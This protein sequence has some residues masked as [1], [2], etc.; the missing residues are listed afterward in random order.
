VKSLFSSI[1]LGASVASIL[2][3]LTKD[4]TITE[5]PDWKRFVQTLSLSD[6]PHSS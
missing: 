1:I 6:Y 4:V 2:A 3:S 5:Q